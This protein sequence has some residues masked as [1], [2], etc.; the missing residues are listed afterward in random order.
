MS[1]SFVGGP[2]QSLGFRA[3]GSVTPH[4]LQYLLQARG[5]FVSGR[6]QLAAV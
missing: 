3:E 5:V 2:P 4:I 6:T 1:P